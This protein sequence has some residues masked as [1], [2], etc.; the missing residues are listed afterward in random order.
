MTQGILL[1]PLLDGAVGLII[2]LRALDRRA[3]GILEEAEEVMR[4]VW[5]GDQMREIGIEIGT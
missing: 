5:A 3:V 4:V 2:E 1:V